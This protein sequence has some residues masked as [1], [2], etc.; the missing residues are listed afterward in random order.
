MTSLLTKI[1]SLHSQISTNTQNISN[2]QNLLTAGTNI[3]F[4]E[5]YMISS[6]GGGSNITQEDLDLKQYLITSSTNLTCNSLN[7]NHL[8]VNNIISTSQF[9]DTIVLRRPTG[10]SGSS[11]NNRIGIREIQCWVNGV[12]IMI[13]N[14]LTSYFAYF[15]NKEADIGP[16]GAS[17]PSTLAYNNVIEINETSTGG[18]LSSSGN[19][20]N[21][22]I[23]K[24]IP[25]T[26][27]IDI[28]ALVLYNRD[29]NNTG[30]VIV[31]VGIELDNSIKDPNLT[32]PL[33][34]TP[35]I[36]STAE[37]VYRYNFPSIDTYT[38]FIGENSITN[39]VNNT[40]AFTQEGIVS[41][42]TEITGDVVVKGDLTVENI[43]VGSHNLITEINGLEI[44][45][46]G[47][48]NILTQGNI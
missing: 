14:G 40:F 7:T 44:E 45:L 46:S 3:I 30:Q 37:L 21:A 12:N 31:G 33:A 29:I 9:F 48:Q 15:L 25:L 1:K 26:L 10:I 27:I 8:E 2:K 23:I 24:N 5:N 20:N 17:S 22:L 34:T 43:I 39:I 42:Y 6:G 13:D 35:V 47:K 19:V 32:K 41:S 28:Q 36:T 38:N 16:Q 4:D 11:G 18:A